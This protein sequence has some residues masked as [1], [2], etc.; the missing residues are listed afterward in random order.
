MEF[1]SNTNLVKN[2]KFMWKNFA[3][4]WKFR[5]TNF[6]QTNFL[7]IIFQDVESSKHML[8]VRSL[9]PIIWSDLIFNLS[10]YGWHQ[11]K[12]NQRMH[13]FTDKIVDNK[14][15]EFRQL[16]KEDIQDISENYGRGKIKRQ[17][18]FLD[19]LIFAMDIENEIDLGFNFKNKLLEN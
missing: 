12:L 10:P 4:N 13:A 11:K 8:R 17:L 16:S 6:G 15:A 19:T 7:I 18:A 5:S 9:N 1:F 3:Q 14:I 2:C